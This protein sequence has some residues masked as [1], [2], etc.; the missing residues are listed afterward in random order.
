MN[1]VDENGRAYFTYNTSS[2][3]VGFVLDMLV[4]VYIGVGAIFSIFLK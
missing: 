4:V 1:N 3:W 2:R